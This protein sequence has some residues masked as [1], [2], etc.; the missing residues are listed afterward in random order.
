M[1]NDKF[2]AFLQTSKAFKPSINWEKKKTDWVEQVNDLY[3]FIEQSLSSFDGDI[4]LERKPIELNEEFVGRYDTEN[5]ILR[6]PS[7]EVLFNPRGLNVIGAQGRV[8]VD[9]PMGKVKLVLVPKSASKVEINVNVES[10]L[11]PHD[12]QSSPHEDIVWK[13]ATPAPNIRFID[14]TQENLLDA[15]ME[16]VNG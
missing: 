3:R 8:D 2:M 16:V 13:I 12:S 14:L 1:T 9:G 15:I 6:L 11:M 5:L 10:E 4:E 7:A